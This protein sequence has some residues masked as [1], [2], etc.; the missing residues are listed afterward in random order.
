MV[1]SSVPRPAALDDWDENFP[2][3]ED[4]LPPTLRDDVLTPQ[5]KLRRLSRTDNDIGSHRDIG[6]FGMTSSSFS[7][8][9]SPLASSP[10][11]FGARRMVPLGLP[12]L[13]LA[14][15]SVNLR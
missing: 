6:G 10:S 13:T 15:R 14:P 11:R 4:Y 12:S 7:K 3:E 8:T 1:S 9:G 5:E 2:M